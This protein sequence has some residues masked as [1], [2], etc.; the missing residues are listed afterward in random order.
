M[1]T[2][3]TRRGGNVHGRI[4]LLYA[5]PELATASTKDIQLDASALT[6]THNNQMTVRTSLCVVAHLLGPVHSS[7]VSRYAP[8]LSSVHSPVLN[9]FIPARVWVRAII[10]LVADL[11]NRFNQMTR[12]W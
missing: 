11:S 5:P 3:R 8:P 9:I 10:E 1:L 2:L 4:V 12:V 6:E 7:L